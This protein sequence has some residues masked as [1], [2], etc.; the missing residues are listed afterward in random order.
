VGLAI[1]LLAFLLVAWLTRVLQDTAAAGDR[2]AVHL[3]RVTQGGRVLHQ[4]LDLEELLPAFATVAAEVVPLAHLSV[5]IDD[6]GAPREVFRTGQAVPSGQ[7]RATAPHSKARAGDAFEISLTRGWRTVGSVVFVATRAV[8]ED[9]MLS[10]HAI[11]DV[12]AAALANAEVLRR[13]KENV[14]RLAEVD[15]LKDSFLGTVSHELRTSVTAV[16]GF[17][18][19]LAHKW[20]SLT[21]AERREFAR[22][23]GRNASSL[24]TLVDQLLDFARLEQG[25]LRVTPVHADLAA[26]VRAALDQLDILLASHVVVAD[27]EAPVAAYVDPEVVERVLANLLSNA[28]K[29]APPGSGVTVSTGLAG[30]QAE[31]VVADQGPGVRHEDRALI[32]TRFYRGDS[33]VAVATRGAGIGLAVVRELVE[34]SWGTV[35][36][37]DVEGGGA[38]FVV[39]FP[40]GAPA[41]V[42]ENASVTGGDPE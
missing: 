25:T 17:A 16:T 41:E 20:D 28:A 6:A 3:E 7:A 30:E 37:E 39:R 23:V 11:A 12:L 13:E 29:Y 40:T 8:D 10:L 42:H 18:D 24:G 4:S 21:N 32:F 36:V 34:R 22:R 31:L 19:L 5:R 38:R 2:R 9:E 1:A 15:R 14:Q 26:L 33:P 27:L 35:R